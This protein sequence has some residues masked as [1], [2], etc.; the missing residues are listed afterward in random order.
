MA[1]IPDD[2]KQ[3][4]LLLGLGAVALV[5]LFHLYWYS[6]RKETADGLAEHLEQLEDRNRRARIVA[7]RGGPELEERLAAYERHL[8]QLEQLIPE[9]EEVPALLNSMALEA[10]NTEVD[11]ALMRPEPSEQGEFYSKQIYEIG[12]V[13][14]YHNVGRFLASIASL[15]RIVSPVD[16]E[17]LPFTRAREVVEG[18]APVEARFRIQ[19]Y[20]VPDDLPEQGDMDVAGGSTG[21]GD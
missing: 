7:S 2:P 8:F 5:T 17:L 20:I 10:R 4:A 16:L 3:R 6:P 18:E 1:L 12:V 19:T 11:L 21:G 13:G 15:P 9:R 14:D